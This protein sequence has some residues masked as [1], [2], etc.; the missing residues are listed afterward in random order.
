MPHFDLCPPVA[1]G[2]Q[3][4]TTLEEAAYVLRQSA[5]RDGDRIAWN[6]AR[7]MREVKTLAGAEASECQ[8]RAWLEMQRFAKPER[9]SA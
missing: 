4:V 6:I 5:I 9:R 1:I 3:L 2:G 7:G 8:L